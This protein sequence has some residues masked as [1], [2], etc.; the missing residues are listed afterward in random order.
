MTLKRFQEIYFA[1]QGITF[2]QRKQIFVSEQE[3]DD[4]SDAVNSESELRH[5]YLKQRILESGVQVGERCCLK[6][7]YHLVED[8]L[9]KKDPSAYPGDANYD[10]VITYNETSGQYGL[11]I[12]DGGASYIAIR[13]CPWCG[14]RLNNLSRE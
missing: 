7:E 4:Y 14:S 2:D 5:W 8:Y 6:M 1:L 3:E 10:A 12:Y 11:P 9:W 13:F